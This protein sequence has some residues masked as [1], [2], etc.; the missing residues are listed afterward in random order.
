MVKPFVAWLLAI[1]SFP[2]KGLSLP[3]L[4]AEYTNNETLGSNATVR[5]VHD[6]FAS[7]PLKIYDPFHKDIG[8]TIKLKDPLSG[9]QKTRFH[10]TILENGVI[11][12]NS[13]AT[14]A[15]WCRFRCHHYLTPM[16]HQAGPWTKL[17]KGQ[18]KP[19]V[20]D[21]VRTECFDARNISIEQNIHMNI[22]E[23]QNRTLPS[24]EPPQP[25]NLQPD[26]HVI[27]LD[28]VS[29]T[30]ARRSLPRT[31]SYLENEL[32]AVRF[33]H[34]NKVGD[35]SMPN[36]FAFLLG[37]R[38]VESMRSVVGADDLQPDHPL[39]NICQEYRDDD[40][41]IFRE[42][43]ALGFQHPEANHIFRP[44]V[45]SWKTDYTLRATMTQKTCF[46]MHI[47][48]LDYHKKFLRA[49]KGIPKFGLTWIGALVHDDANMLFHTDEHFEDF[50]KSNRDYL[51]NSFVFFMADHG[52]RIGA[53]VTTDLGRREI[54][55]PMLHIVVPEW[56]RKNDEVQQNLAS[57]ANMLLTPFDVHATFLDIFE[58]VKR[59]NF[60]N[61]SPKEV[62]PAEFNANN[63][64]SLLRQSRRFAER[65]CRNIPTDAGYCL[66][67]YSQK[68]VNKPA[69]AD[70]MAQLGVDEI[71]GIVEEAGVASRCTTLK[72]GSERTLKAYVPETHTRL[73]EIVFQTLPDHGKFK[74]MVRIGEGGLLQ[75]VSQISRLNAY[76]NR[77]CVADSHPQLR[78]YC[79]CK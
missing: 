30:Q 65:N 38:I 2:V 22:A 59:G 69:L 16:R 27:V 67:E 47:A 53:T 44:M 71:N 33:N 14:E 70:G 34:L 21:F 66:C 25:G 29:S 75:R 68:A 4:V 76:G 15:E 40:P 32:E 57:N 54:N 46:E 20:C 73:Y 12:M 45:T 5:A 17:R 8:G 79:H 7:C 26:I 9:C 78:I 74:M 18:T 62:I 77:R 31:L 50:F 48:Q 39:K 19:I 11:T 1:R 43:E 37:W 41:V 64:S 72:L 10:M 23:H 42:F 24:R 6:L 35:N 56:M 28:S 63:G 61:F 36:G 51:K 55:N 58:E 3:Y 49:Y 13:F 52:M 60:T